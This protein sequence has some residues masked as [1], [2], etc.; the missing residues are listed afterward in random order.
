MPLEH[1]R[2]GV[3]ARPL[4]SLQNGK[5]RVGS[6]AVVDGRGYDSAGGALGLGLGPARTRRCQAAD[7]KFLQE[8]GGGR[9]ADAD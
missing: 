7:Y 6:V 2:L 4:I 3:S 1:C 9:R 5:R 8:I